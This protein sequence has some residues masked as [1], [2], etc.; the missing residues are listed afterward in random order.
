[1]IRTTELVSEMYGGIEQGWIKMCKHNRDEHASEIEILEWAS[2]FGTRMHA[3]A[4]EN[5]DTPK[6]EI[7][8]KCLEQYN[9]FKKKY[10]PKVIFTE[11]SFEYEDEFGDV[12]YTGTPDLLVRIRG[13]YILIDLKFW[14]VWRYAFDYEPPKKKMDGLKQTKANLQ[15]TLYAN[16]KKDKYKIDGRAVLWITPD[17]YMFKEFRNEATRFKEAIEYAKSLKDEESNF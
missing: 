10:A 4:L 13:K 3:M 15:T 14:G 1:M 6:T 16:A 8:K 12:I 17:F 7:E 5:N 11:E 9:L 2:E